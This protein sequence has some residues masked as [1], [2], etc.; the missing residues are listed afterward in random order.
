MSKEPILSFVKELCTFSPRLG[1]NEQK[2]AHFIKETLKNN[3]ISFRVEKFHTSYPKNINTYLKVDGE[4]I[5]CQPTTFLDGKIKRKFQL[6]NSLVDSPE[7]KN[8]NFNPKSTVLSL[9]Q[10]YFSPAM[11]VN[12]KDIAKIKEAEEIDGSIDV[13]RTSYLAQNILV[14]NYEDPLFLVFAHYDCLETGA[15]DNGSGA[16]TMMQLVLENPDLLSSGLFIFSGNEELSYDRP[17]YWGR[18]FR[19][20]EKRHPHFFKNTKQVLVI[21]CV[22]NGPARLTKNHH[23]VTECFPIKNLKV[24]KDKTFVLCADI[25]KLYNVY[26]SQGDDPEQLHETK[27]RQALELAKNHLNAL[28]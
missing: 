28:K 20:F 18:G 16:A 10:F 5:K 11:A 17:V 15:T 4:K 12:K 1:Q 23:L 13:D 3:H 2:A 7:G 8:L 27:L 9:A 6:I 14:G 19:M 26:H 25:G 24:L 21:D 22:G